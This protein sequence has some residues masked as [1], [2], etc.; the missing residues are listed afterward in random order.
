MIPPFYIF[1]LFINDYTQH[2]Q[3]PA[4]SAFTSEGCNCMRYSAIF[5]ASS[6]D[7]SGYFP[8]M[9]FPGL[10]SSGSF[11]HFTKFSFVGNKIPANLERSPKLVKSGPI[12]TRSEERRVGQ[13][14]R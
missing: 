12:G 11:N 8:V 4:L 10:I 9:K 7:S 6:S 1:H 2:D 3:L 5:S 13:E 14:C